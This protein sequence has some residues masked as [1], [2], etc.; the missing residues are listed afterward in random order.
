MG[1]RYYY[2]S[3][4][5]EGGDWLRY[6]PGRLLI[7]HLLEWS[8]RRGLKVF[9]FTVGNEE[10]KFEY[11]DVT[12]PLYRVIVPETTIGRSPVSQPTNRPMVD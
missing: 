8:F 12:I 6:S 10:Y 1:S 7:E 11:S 9:D 5:F 3:P 2:L 4:S